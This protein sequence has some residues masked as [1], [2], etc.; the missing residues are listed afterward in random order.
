MLFTYYLQIYILLIIS[1]ARIGWN[2][3]EHELERSGTRKGGGESPRWHGMAQV[4]AVRKIFGSYWD[5]I[6]VLDYAVMKVL[7]CF[8]CQLGEE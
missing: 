1:T 4:G 3:S 8:C 5:C 7:C 6:G 2:C